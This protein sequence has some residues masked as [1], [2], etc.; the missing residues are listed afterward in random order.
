MGGGEYVSNQLFRTIAGDPMIAFQ[1]RCALTGSLLEFFERTPASPG[2]VIERFKARLAQPDL[3]AMGRVYIMDNEPHPGVFFELMAA[4]WK[5]WR[6]ELRWDSV[7]G[8]LT[9]RAEQD[10]AGHVLIRINLRS[11]TS[12]A[13]WSLDAI[14]TAEAGQLEALANQAS[15][16]FGVSGGSAATSEAQGQPTSAS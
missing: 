5:G 9:L 4:N 3:S 6:G 7:D 2:Q 1:V 16:F 14:I 11:G 8:A 15:S 13:D 10:C 12:D